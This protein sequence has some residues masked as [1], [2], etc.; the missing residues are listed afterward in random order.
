MP[1][2]GAAMFRFPHFGTPQSMIR[3][4]HK[5]SQTILPTQQLSGSALTLQL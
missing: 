1:R 3:M 2:S 4:P 5:E